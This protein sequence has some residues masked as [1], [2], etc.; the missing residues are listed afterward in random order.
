MLINIEILVSD[1]H[2]KEKA[3]HK[4]ENQAYIN[5]SRFR[6]TQKGF[7]YAV[8]HC[9]AKH[10]GILMTEPKLKAIQNA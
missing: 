1:G 7:N 6:L 3:I 5:L 9:L 8:Q 4:M 10:Q 2:I